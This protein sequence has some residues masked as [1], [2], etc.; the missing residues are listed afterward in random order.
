V[1]L[2]RTSLESLDWG[3]WLDMLEEMDDASAVFLLD[4][5]VRS[6]ARL[7]D[8][9]SEMRADIEW[10]APQDCLL[11]EECLSPKALAD[12]LK[13]AFA[14]KP[15]RLVCLSH[16]GQCPAMIDQTRPLIE[17]LGY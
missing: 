7:V 4:E 13:A 5:D 12:Q 1:Y 14:R 3:D 16:K 6:D 17:L 11:I 2:N 15:P 9:L 8:K 10:I